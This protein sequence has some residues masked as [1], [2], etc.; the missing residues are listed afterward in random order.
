MNKSNGIFWD[1]DPETKELQWLTINEAVEAYLGN[2]PMEDWPGT[3]PV[4]GFR[5]PR[6]TEKIDVMEWLKENKPEWILPSN[7]RR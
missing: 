4:Y 2:I 5:E 1:C 3:L 7:H 6:I